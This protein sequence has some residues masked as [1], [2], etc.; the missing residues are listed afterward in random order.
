MGP[1]GLGPMTGRGMGWCRGDPA[2]FMRAGSP[3]FGMGWG[4][5]RGG[6]WRHR[7]WY[8]ATGLPGWQRA[9]TAWPGPG[10]WFPGSFAPVPS[11]EEELGALQQQA[12]N[13]ER[14]LGE[15]RTR[16]Q[17]LRKAEADVTPPPGG[18]AR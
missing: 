4:A 7:H 16:M 13:V 2:P 9:W 1:L 3:E 10:G 14:L 15:L 11:R 18:E 12:A 8:Y 5:G 6:G 17:E